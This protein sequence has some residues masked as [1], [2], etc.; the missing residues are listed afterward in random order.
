MELLCSQAAQI[1]AEELNEVAGKQAPW[2]T[3][4]SWGYRCT[5]N[6]LRPLFLS[7][8]LLFI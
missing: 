4:V 6:Q 2:S 8:G 3:R 7:Q 1:L 5:L